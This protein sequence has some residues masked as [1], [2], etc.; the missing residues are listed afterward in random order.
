MNREDL[1][2]IF[3]N[4]REDNVVFWAVIN[5][6]NRTVLGHGIS[7]TSEGAVQ[8]AEGLISNLVEETNG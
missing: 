2:I 8:H 1:W 6:A 3:E 5:R 7:N 4:N